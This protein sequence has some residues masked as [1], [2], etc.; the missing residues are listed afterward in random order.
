MLKQFLTFTCIMVLAVCQAKAQQQDLAG[1]AQGLSPTQATAA[2]AP[3]T[4]KVRVPRRAGLK[5]ETLAPLTSATAKVGDNVP[6]RLARPLVINNVTVLPAGHMATARV[7][8]VQRASA[9]HDGRVDWTLDRVPFPDSTT[10]KTKI[11]SAGPVLKVPPRLFHEEDAGQLDGM[12]ELPTLNEW[13]E[14][15]LAA[16]LYAFEIACESPFLAIV[17]LALLFD[18]FNSSCTVPGKEYELPANSAVA[19][20]ITK[21]HTVQ[22]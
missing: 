18:S 5:F 10:A 9:C 1:V 7:I 19:V 2:S 15:P 3:R 11:W 8:R 17:G 12:L 16:P 13:W 6:L 14:A 21:S 4:H 20:M 22:Y